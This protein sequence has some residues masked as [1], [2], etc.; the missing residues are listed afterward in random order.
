MSFD[1]SDV[2]RRLYLDRI[3][4]LLPVPEIINLITYIIRVC[5]GLKNLIWLQWTLL[6][7]YSDIKKLMKGDMH[8]EKDTT[9]S[10]DTDYLQPKKKGIRFL[11]PLT[12][13]LLF[14]DR[15]SLLS[16]RTAY[17][18]HEEKLCY[19]SAVKGFWKNFMYAFLTKAG[20]S[21]LLSLLRPSRFF[22]NLLGVLSKDTL[23]FCLFVGGLAGIFKLTL[24]SMRRLR[25]TDDGINAAIAGAL[26]GL[27]LAFEASGN[28]K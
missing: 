11:K 17:C 10:M 13:L 19:I 14:L 27:S 4:G 23:S 3:L 7:K 12:K 24:C 15:A 5:L 28:R 25:G 26:A 6:T 18:K 2:T 16:I 8:F 20:I 22:K 1:P 21:I 9:S